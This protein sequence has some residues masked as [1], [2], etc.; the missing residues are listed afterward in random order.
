M[1]LTI[2]IPK[3][4]RA[5]PARCLEPGAGERDKVDG[6]LTSGQV[7]S[8]IANSPLQV[9]AQTSTGFWRSEKFRDLH[10]NK[11]E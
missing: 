6:S 3:W 11:L 1:R 10:S 2:V 4:Q 8:R 9:G 5:R 7:E